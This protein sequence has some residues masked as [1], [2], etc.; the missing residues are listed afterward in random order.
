MSSTNTSSTDTT[1]EKERPGPHWRI[2][3]CIEALLQDNDSN[4]PMM[5]EPYRSTTIQV[6]GMMEQW[7]HAWAGDSAWHS[8][9]N[10]RS[11]HHEAEESIVAL[12]HLREW[13][14]KPGLAKEN[15]DFVAVDVCGGKGFF[16]MLLSFMASTYWQPQ[17]KQ[18]TESGEGGEE[19]EGSNPLVRALKRIILLEK[20]TTKDIDWQHVSVANAR[21]GP[22]PIIELWSDTNLHEYDNLLSKFQAVAKDNNA[23]LAMT[24]IHLCKM[25]SPSCISLANGLGPACPYLLLAPCCLPRVVTNA[26]AKREK[27]GPQTIPIYTHETP[28]AHQER[29]KHNQ[30]K[31]VARSNRACFHCQQKGHWVKQCAE[32]KNLTPQEQS[33]IIQASMEA[34]PCWICGVVG[35]F[36]ADCPTPN[37][38]SAKI[39]TRYPPTL[40]MD[41]SN[42]MDSSTPFENYCSLLANYIR[43]DGTSTAMD[44]T[45]C[46]PVSTTTEEEPSV[47]RLKASN[48]K[49]VEAGL[50]GNNVHE[51]KHEGNWN[52]RRKSIF[53]IASR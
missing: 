46:H 6:A 34:I 23:L 11:I 47:K 9:L 19:E 4:N 49:V 48:V 22:H 17:Q 31:L 13:M 7:A 51:K 26:A 1:A 32:L 14:T 15:L 39:T 38:K 30:R 37:L 45:M 5:A 21:E 24:G 52:A 42:I 18:R 36:R 35:H 8:F 28:Q 20:A 50:T 40:A 10:K 53:L 44:G 12:Y 43:I 25:L 27:K 29:L 2:W 41:V 33:K 16:S 3:C